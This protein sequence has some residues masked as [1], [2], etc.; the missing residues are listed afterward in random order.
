MSMTAPKEDT[1]PMNDET[2]F[3]QD[4]RASTGLRKVIALVLLC[5]ALVWLPACHKK[6]DA[7]RVKE[8]VTTIQK[9]AGDK[10]I[11]KI[12]RNLSKTYHDSH[13]NDYDGMKAFLLGYFFRHQ[14]ISV[15]IT[16]LDV[17]VSG[18]KAQA[19]FHA[20]LSGGKKTESL[21]TLLPES[22]GMYAFTV[23][24]AKED[25]DWKVVSADWKR[26][27]NGQGEGE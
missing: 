22:L 23:D 19:V 6:T 8:V 3:S 15:Y 4:R 18:T 11:G 1:L 17:T 2:A 21:S 7:D 5:A 26:A 25:G 16:D 27:G 13:G 10:D 12:L 14:K 20:I 24:F 9:A